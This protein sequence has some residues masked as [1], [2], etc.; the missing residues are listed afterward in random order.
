[1]SSDDSTYG[2]S[3]G[4]HI[5]LPMARS[6]LGVPAVAL[7]IS[8]TLC[9]FI[10]AE[11]NLVG[12]AIVVIVC[13]SSAAR[14]L[15]RDQLMFWSP[16]LW[17]CLAAAAY[18][19][20]GPLVYRFAEQTT[21]ARINRYFFVDTAA[22]ARTNVL[23]AIGIATVFF[24]YE[25]TRGKPARTRLVP[26]RSV[27]FHLRVAFACL[28]V[29]TIC[30]VV[31]GIIAHGTRDAIIPGSLQA[32]MQ[33]SLAA[34]ATLAY[35]VASPRRTRLAT[36]LLALTLANQLSQ[37]VFTFS[38][39]TVLEVLLAAA[40]G[41]YLARPS[42]RLIAVGVPAGALLYLALVPFVN[43]G[44]AVLWQQGGSAADRSF[45]WY[46]HGARESS[47]DSDV[48]QNAWA[49]LTYSNAQAFVM[50]QYDNGEHGV[51]FLLAPVVFIPRILWPEKPVTTV[52]TDFNVMVTGNPNSKSAPGLFAEAYWNGGWPLVVI[53]CF[54]LG[55]L[56]A[57][58]AHVVRKRV[59]DSLDSRWM[60]FALICLRMGYRIDGWCVPETIGRVPIALVILALLYLLVPRSTLSVVSRYIPAP[61]PAS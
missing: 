16:M 17:F 5:T 30:S 59:V 45:L 46:V 50:R 60:P 52:G 38:K 56:F 18:Y 9:Q 57:Q 31:A 7:L 48:T 11:Y 21:I 25:I 33:L 3:G 22:L 44:R 47:I 4:R 37:A 10:G 39:E 58:L 1:M 28:G 20:V 34:L 13:L 55:S 29:S 51:T 43:F 26:A 61:S 49:R 41:V 8:A 12:P 15:R 54:A 19:G 6:V 23:D 27:K 40:C 36:W 35:I 53:T 14:L 2:A 24:A 32:G 42:R